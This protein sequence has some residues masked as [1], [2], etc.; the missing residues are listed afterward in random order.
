MFRLLPNARLSILP[1]THGAYIG[2]VTTGMGNNKILSLTVS[3]IEEFL[4]DPIP[5]KK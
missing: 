5:G 1:G 3:M 4:N 2:E